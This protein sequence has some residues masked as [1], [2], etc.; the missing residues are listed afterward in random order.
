MDGTSGAALDLGSQRTFVTVKVVKA[1]S[2]E[3]VC[4][5][6]LAI[7]TFEQGTSGSE[8][9]SVRLDLKPL[10]GR[11]LVSVKACVVPEISVTKNQH[12]EVA[13]ESFAHLRDLWLSDV[14]KSSEDLEVDVLV[15]ADDLSELKGAEL[16]WIDASQLVMKEQ[17]E[18]KQSQ[19]QYGLV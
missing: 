1:F 9:R 10:V 14:C 11:E 5:E 18:Y 3:V 15:G 19:R 8:L 2:C 6:N 17:V 16:A 12:L 4:E 13:R 7:G